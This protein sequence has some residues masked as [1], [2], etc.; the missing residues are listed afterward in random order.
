MLIRHHDS[1]KE[2]LRKP[3]FA[4]YSGVLSFLTGGE[5]REALCASA[6]LTAVVYIILLYGKAVRGTI[7]SPVAS[8][9]LVLCNYDTDA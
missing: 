1:V 7:S 5:W 4:P 6:G 8:G 2:S 9:K 3:F